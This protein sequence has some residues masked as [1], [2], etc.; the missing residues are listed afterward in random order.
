MW[1]LNTPFPSL[2]GIR[3]RLLDLN[4]SPSAIPDSLKLP[5]L[6]KLSNIFGSQYWQF[7]KTEHQIIFKPLLTFIIYSSIVTPGLKF[8]SL[9]T[10]ESL[11]GGTTEIGALSLYFH[12]YDTLN[13]STEVCFQVNDIS[14]WKWKVGLWTYQLERVKSVMVGQGRKKRRVSGEKWR[15]T[16][17]MLAKDLPGE[18]DLLTIDKLWGC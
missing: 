12:S 11:L 18:S 13:T 14:L 1:L 7:I 5:D 10:N 8:S 17:D 4:L 6:N 16:K 9:V 15:A 3:G 2:A